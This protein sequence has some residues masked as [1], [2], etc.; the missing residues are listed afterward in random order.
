MFYSTPPGATIS[1][2]V[3]GKRESLGITP[4][5]TKLDPRKS[6]QVLFEKPGYVSVNRPIVFTGALEEQLNVPLEKAS[7]A[8][9]KD[10]VKA[11]ADVR[12]EKVDRPAKA[13]TTERTE[14]KKRVEKTDAKE[15]KTEPPPEKTEKVEKVEKVEN[16]QKKPPDQ[17]DE[18]MRHC[19][20]ALDG[21]SSELRDIDGGVRFTIRVP[22][23]AI[24]EA[25]RRSHHIVEF[26]A[27]RTRE[28]HGDFDGK[29][30]GRMRNCPVVTDDVTITA[31]DTESGAQLDIVTD[32]ARVEAL[33]VE[34]R[35]RVKRF[36]FVGAT[37]TTP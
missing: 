19:P 12:P 10:E 9:A 26:A 28:G 37:I 27:K 24:A 20:V 21:A 23:A 30:G 7:G 2:I 29:G 36:P 22:E 33:R 16:V 15:D 1:L 35:E 14:K 13:E 34:T 31:S 18:R 4:A 17:M 3:D 5:K 11:V 32:A 6:Y 8:A 25:R